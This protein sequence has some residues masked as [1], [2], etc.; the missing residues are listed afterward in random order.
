MLSDCHDL[1]SYLSN[2]GPVLGLR[3][4]ASF[5]PLHVPGRDPTLPGIIDLKRKPFQAQAAIISAIT[6][7]WKRQKTCWL[8]GECGVGKTT[9]GAA[10]THLAGGK[11]YRAL[12]MA[13]DHLL[14]KWKEEIE[15]TCKGA[16]VQIFGD[17]KEVLH[18]SQTAVKPTGPEWL[19]LGRDKSKGDPAWEM[20]FNTKRIPINAEDIAALRAKGFGW[21]ELTTKVAQCPRCGSIIVDKDDVPIAVK[22]LKA[23][24]LKCTGMISRWRTK[25]DGSVE[26]VDTPCNE[27]LWQFVTA[28]TPKAREARKAKLLAEGKK[29]SSAPVRWA[30][31]RIIHANLKRRIDYLI[32][33]ELHELKGDEGT[34]QA[35]AMGALVA[36]SVKVLGMTGTLIGGRADHIFPMMMRMAPQSLL[37]QGIGWKDNMK[38]NER[39]G[40]IET[41]IHS[42]GGGTSVGKDGTHSKSSS[43][44]RT[45]KNVKPGIMP[46]LFG[47]HLVDKCCFLTLE[48]VAKEAGDA[49]LLP[50]LHEE[51]ITLDMDPE[52][53][54]SYANLQS[55]FKNVIK[56]MLVRGDQRL[57]GKMLHT[58]L[59]YPDMPYN[60]DL[61]DAGEEGCFQPKNLDARMVRAK[62]QAIIDYALRE[63][64]EGRKLW[65]YLQMTQIR[66]YGERAVKFLGDVGL[67]VGYMHSDRPSR[68]ERSD[69]IYKHAPNYDVILSHPK[70]VETGL[71]LFAK[72]GNHNFPS[73]FFAQT[74]YNLF[75]LRQASRRSWRLAQTLPCKTAFCYYKQTL[76][77]GAMQLMGRKLVAAEAIEGKFSAEGLVAMA[78]EEDATIA[79][80]KA[81]CAKISTPADRAWKELGFAAIKQP[82]QQPRI[83]GSLPLRPAPVAPAPAAGFTGSEIEKLR[84]LMA[85]MGVKVS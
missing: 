38:F 48:D 74:G 83:I 37:A 81:L 67:R 27:Q 42:K 70:L 8:V 40:R 33:D 4:T 59:A 54:E 24:R 50:T 12:V 31:Y 6:A 84:A 14:K 36:S 60:W 43:S 65:V 80:A 72:N 1:S 9:V 78:G 85:L 82:A 39:Y 7:T 53:A 79:L 68:G 25:D 2:Y 49:G 35:N 62:D 66:D 75:T 16:T 28:G 76:Q 73:L 20:R 19:I 77:E 18:Y 11:A 51:V 34:A 32:C 56:A 46:Q 23:K 15:D 55:W 47:E 21:D 45:S 5:N 69:W 57:L 64:G 71:D 22:E 17:W 61:I 13:P 30:P 3:A 29:Q 44:C 58:L 52:L 26:T 10:I 41:V 63:A